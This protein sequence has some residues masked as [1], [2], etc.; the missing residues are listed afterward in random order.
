MHYISGMKRIAAFTVAASLAM[1][2]ALAQ[3]GD[4]GEVGEGLNLME[5]GA[6]LLFRGLMAEMEPAMKD[7]Q[8]LA[9][10]MAPAFAELMGMIGDFSKYHA[11]EV[12]PNGDIIIRRKVPLKVEPQEDGEIDL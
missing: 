2:P 3:T 4:K 10:E 7:L 6:K 1:S 5:E 9:D 8:G 11:P 12:L